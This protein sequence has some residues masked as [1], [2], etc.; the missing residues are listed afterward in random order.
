MNIVWLE[1]GAA[2]LANKS[3]DVRDINFAQWNECSRFCCCVVNFILYFW[4]L[5]SNEG[6]IMN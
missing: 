2:M 4:L 3:T 6:P 1:S 5:D